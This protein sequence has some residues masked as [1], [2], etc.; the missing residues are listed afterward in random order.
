MACVFAPMWSRMGILSLLKTKTKGFFVQMEIEDDDD[1][2]LQDTNSLEFA[3]IVE[4][5]FFVL[6]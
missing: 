2:A 1:E 5:L 3:C 4:F 6:K